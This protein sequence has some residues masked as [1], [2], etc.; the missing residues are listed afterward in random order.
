MS[1][2][3]ELICNCTSKLII[4]FAKSDPNVPF[5]N[6]YSKTYMKILN[7]LRNNVSI[8]VFQIF[9]YDRP[10]FFSFTCANKCA[11]E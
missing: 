10:S 5:S 4:I 8:T 9:L 1:H 7:F 2:H 6:N 11:Y 3:E